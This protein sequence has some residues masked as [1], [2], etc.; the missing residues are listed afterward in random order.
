MRLAVKF[1]GILKIMKKVIIWFLVLI[2]LLALAVRFS[3]Q[4]PDSLLGIKQKSG[5]SIT[6]TPEGAIV[7]L[8]GKEVG[9]TPFSDET[10]EPKT[11]V[12]KLDKDGFTLQGKLSLKPNTVLI[13]NR[14]LAKDTTSSAGEVLSL[15]KGKGITVVS[16]PSD[17]QIEVDGKV[18]GK[19]PLVVDIGMGEHS[20]VI[21]H[22]NYLKRS[23]SAKLPEGFNL[24]VVADMAISEVD[25]TTFT[26]PTVSTT[27]EVVVKNTPTGFLRVREKPSLAGKE[28]AQV[29]PGDVLILLSEEGSWVRVRLSDKTEGYVSATYVEKK[30]K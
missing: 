16:N 7:S 22:P 5:I 19:T 12:V 23:L 25:L 1:V 18:Y 4:I 13:V 14:D 26:A 6:S 15:E 30:T 21:S 3:S 10:L 17:A 8:D 20:I 27:A 11:V 24:T 29:K 2:S 28:I 9:K